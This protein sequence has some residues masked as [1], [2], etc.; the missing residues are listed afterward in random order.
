MRISNIPAI[1]GAL[2]SGFAEPQ[3]LAL[4]PAAIDGALAG[5]LD[6]H[7]LHEIVPDG[8][9]QQGAAAGFALA[10]SVPSSMH[11]R[12]LHFVPMKSRSPPRNSPGGGTHWPMPRSASRVI[13]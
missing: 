8:I 3:R 12:A 6:R 5:G 2:S 10:R 13:P 4:G 11:C 1:S 7:R 9:F